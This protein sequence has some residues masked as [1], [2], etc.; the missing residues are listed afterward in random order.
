MV[1][2][3]GLGHN[4]GFKPEPTHRRAH[5]SAEQPA[6]RRRDVEEVRANALVVRAR[7]DPGDQL[8]HERLVRSGAFPEQRARR[9]SHFP[10]PVN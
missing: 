1:A 9:A 6:E 5:A 2:R 7:A 10:P 3:L 8:T 4:R